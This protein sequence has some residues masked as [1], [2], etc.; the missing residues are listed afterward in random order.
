MRSV[1]LP[2]SVG[3]L[4]TQAARR[5]GDKTALVFIRRARC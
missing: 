2:T 5:F 1:A 4:L 3:A